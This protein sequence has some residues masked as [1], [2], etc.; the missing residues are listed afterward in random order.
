M[1]RVLSRFVPL[2]GSTELD[3]VCQ[4]LSRTLRASPRGVFRGRDTTTYLMNLGLM[5]HDASEH[6]ERARR[7]ERAGEAA[8]ERACRGVRG[9]KPLG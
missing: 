9:A 4:C 7:T 8:S 3:S 1:G 2:V 5:F 6:R